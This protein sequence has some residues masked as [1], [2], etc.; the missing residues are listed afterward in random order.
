MR[1][2][3]SCVEVGSSEAG[4]VVV[5]DDEDDEDDEKKSPLQAKGNLD[6]YIHLAT[7]MISSTLWCSH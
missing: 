5:V 7:F 6:F 3:V 2:G 1:E 4:R